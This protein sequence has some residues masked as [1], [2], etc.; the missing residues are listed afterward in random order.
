MNISST[1][2]L[3]RVNSFR[4]EEIYRNDILPSVKVKHYHL[5]CLVCN[6]RIL[7]KNEFGL[8]FYCK[9]D[10]RIKHYN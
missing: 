6:E 4:A 8:C 3:M 10:K 9:L 1:T 5:K 7:N 2:T